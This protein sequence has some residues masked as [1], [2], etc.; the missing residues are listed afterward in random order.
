MHCLSNVNE[1]VKEFI[2]KIL[3]EPNLIQPIVIN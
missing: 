1:S 2:K 3:V